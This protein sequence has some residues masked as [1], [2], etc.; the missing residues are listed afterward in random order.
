[1]GVVIQAPVPEGMA[2]LPV[3]MAEVPRVAED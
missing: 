1:M 2:V 3:G